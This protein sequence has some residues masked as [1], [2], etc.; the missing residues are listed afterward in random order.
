MRLITNDMMKIKKTTPFFSSLLLSAV[1]SLTGT[2]LWAQQSQEIFL[3]DP[4]IFVENG[5]Y[6]LTGTGGSGPATAGFSVL[7]SKDLK[8]WSVPGNTRDS[9]AMLLTKGEGSFGTEGFWAPQILKDSRTYYLTYTANEQTVLA[10]S[11]KVTGPF[12]QSRPEP[13]DGS[14]KNIDSYIFKD[15]D[16]KYYLYHVRFSNGNYLWVAEF[17]L[18]KGRIKPETLTKCFDQ[19]EPWEATPAYESAPIME[20][21]TVLRLNDKYYMF[22]SANHF[23]NIDYAVG[24]AV[25]DSPYG[26]WVKH[27]GNPIIHRTIVGENGSG[28]GDLFEGLDGQLYYVYHTHYSQ[29]EV[30]PRRTRII[31]VNKRWNDQTGLFEFDVDGDKV[32]VPVRAD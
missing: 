19:T 29:D 15:D 31:P 20:G 32:I 8:N 9:V 28:H 26:P 27:E 2:P 21:P 24:Y 22:Y 12:N 5:T 16:G 6:Y 30:A 7:V 23:R 14:E 17:D 1:L 11:A 13:I 4:T 3:A 25:A 10:R 18:D